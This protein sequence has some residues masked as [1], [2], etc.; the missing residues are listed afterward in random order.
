MK[1]KAVIQI[2][3]VL[4]IIVGAYFGVRELAIPE[5]V[6]KPVSRGNATLSATGNVTVLPSAEALITAPEK[7]ILLDFGPR[8]DRSYQEGDP[9]KR[10]D[11]IA[12]LDSGN[13]PFFLQQAQSDL[14]RV[15]EKRKLGSPLQFQ[16]EQLKKDLDNTRQLFAKGHAREADVREL[17]TRFASTELNML[18]E[19]I[20]YD[21]DEQRISILIDQ[22]KDQLDRFAMRAP[23]DGIIMAP[24]YVKGDLVFAGNRIA[25]VTST[26][27]LIKV[28]INQDD[29]SAVRQSKR[30][31]VNFFSFPGQDYEGSVDVLVQ[32]GNSSNQRFTAFLKMKTLP[33]KLLSGQ[34]GEATFVADE[35]HDTLLVPSS[36]IMGNSVFVVKNGVTEKRKIKAG[37]SSVTTVEVLDG[38]S[39]G[40]LVVTKDADTQHN[41]ARVKI[42]G[43]THR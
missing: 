2:L 18:L 35:H 34:T 39:E 17:S 12:R 9:V 29:L 1:I 7:G 8:D 23:F 15:K 11:L 31:L 38:L 22:Y 41:G 10:G 33:E 40:E 37:F 27:K 19:K 16:Y 36:A 20:N 24:A 6:V 30:V 14:D 32:V 25:K 4:G 3:V 26:A 43:E 28:E 13:L 5:V 42:K 21:F